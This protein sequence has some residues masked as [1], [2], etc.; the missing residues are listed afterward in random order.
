MDV[1]YSNFYDLIKHRPPHFRRSLLDEIDDSVRLSCIRGTRGIGKTSMLLEYAADRYPAMGPECLYINLNHFCFSEIP[2]S[3][4]V[5]K[6]VERGGKLLLIDQ[7]FKHEGWEEQLLQCYHNYPNL[8]IVFT[9]SSVMKIATPELKEVVRMYDL[10]GFSFREY[11]CHKHNEQYPSV[12]LPTLFAQHVEIAA[13]IS[14]KYPVAEDFQHYLRTGY[15]PSEQEEALF[16]EQLVKA[17]NMTLEVDVIYIHQID[18]SYLPRLRRL[19]YA[20]ASEMGSV[21]VSLLSKQI[22]VSRAT[23][24]NYLKYLSDAR[25]LSMVYKPNEEYPKKPYEIYLNNTNIA[26]AFYPVRY[27]NQE[28]NRVFLINQLLASHKLETATCKFADYLV[29]SQYHLKVMNNPTRVAKPNLYYAVPDA[30]IGKAD[31]IPLWLFGFLY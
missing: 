28:L 2:L 6:F 10:R 5:Q 25:M 17:M 8:R 13:D 1:F 12:S 26:Q 30:L 16:V 14:R 27:S 23:V 21:N 4:F 22:G 9:G 24:M 20:I 3:N 29:D 31:K 18:P 7:V 15:Y 11:F 19:L